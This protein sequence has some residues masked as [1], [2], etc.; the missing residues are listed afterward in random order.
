MKIQNKT[1]HSIRRTVAHSH[2]KIKREITLL[3]KQKVVTER[4]HQYISTYSNPTFTD[5]GVRI[6]LSYSDNINK[7][8]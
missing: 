8:G 1:L 7:I 2:E 5:K 6:I 3:Q 4:N